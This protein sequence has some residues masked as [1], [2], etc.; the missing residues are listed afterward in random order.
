MRRKL[1]QRFAAHGVASAKCSNCWLLNATFARLT[2]HGT[3]VVKGTSGSDNIVVSNEGSQVAVT[4]NDRTKFFS[5][6][7]VQQLRIDAGAGDDTVLVQV[8]KPATIL[9]GDGNDTLTGGSG[10]DLINGGAGDDSLSG[11][12]GNDTL[13]GESGNDT[14]A[15]GDGTDTAD[16]SDRT[17]GFQF[18]VFFGG[19]GMATSG[20]ETDAT[21]SCEDLIGTNQADSFLRSQYDN[22]MILEGRGGDDTFTIFGYFNAQGTTVL[23]GAG[24]DEVT[25]YCEGLHVTFFGGPGNDTFNE[26]ED[27]ELPIFDGGP[28]VDQ[29][30]EW[31]QLLVTLDM[32]PM[33]SVENATI[34]DGV[35]IGNDGPNVLTAK[36]P[37]P[38]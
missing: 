20:T 28:G 29:I 2:P 34:V 14:L 9:G 21:D 24:D 15:G 30:I 33:K 1:N 3:I 25:D 8:D 7:A 37:S 5:S 22:N 19:S 4:V 38:R 36:G 27:D 26:M 6:A 32:R 35:L 17:T 13:N 12:A 31:P 10:D 18:T 23:G 11:G 16:Y